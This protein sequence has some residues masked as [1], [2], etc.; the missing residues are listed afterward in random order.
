[1]SSITLIGDINYNRLNTKTPLCCYFLFVS[2]VELQDYLDVI[3]F[4]LLINQLSAS[5]IKVWLDV[6]TVCLWEDKKRHNNVFPSFGG[7]S[8]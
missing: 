1:M 6:T 7:Y 3:F 5:N 2:L 4:T 8:F